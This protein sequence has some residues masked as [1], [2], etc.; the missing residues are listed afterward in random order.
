MESCECRIHPDFLVVLA[1]DRQLKELEL[2]C[3]DSEEFCVF[4]ADPTF[5]LFEENIALT[6]TT[7]RN[8]KLIDKETGK[9]PVFI[10]PLLM[11]QHKDWKTYSHFAH[12]VI[13]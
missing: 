5:N 2:F 6:V 12:T 4:G 1:D 11:H 7:Y 8:L 13:I 10:G 9:A 3:T